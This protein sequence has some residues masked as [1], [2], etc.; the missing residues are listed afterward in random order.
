[1]IQ[2]I[3][4]VHQNPDDEDSFLCGKKAF[5]LWRNGYRI[6]GKGISR[7]RKILGQEEGDKGEKGQRGQRRRRGQREK[8][9][10]FSWFE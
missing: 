4:G 1:M 10:I 6:A 9:L 8:K 5:S 2:V 3:F 7:L